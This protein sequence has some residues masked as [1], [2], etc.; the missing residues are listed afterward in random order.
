MAQ[1]TFSI[2]FSHGNQF[3]FG[4]L[5]FAAREDRNLELLTWG[6]APRHPALVY[7]TS[8]YYLIDP[9]TSG[10]ACSGLNPH[11]GPYYLSAKTSQGR[12]IRKTILQ[13]SVGASSSSSLGAT[14]YRDSIEDY[15]EIGSSACWNPAI[16][17][18]RISMVGPTKSNSQNNSSKYPTIGGSKASNE[19]TPSS[20]VV[21][22][23]NLD[24]NAVRL[25]TILESIQRMVPQDSPLMA[26][27]QQGVEAVKQHPQPAATDVWLITTCIGG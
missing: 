2:K 12:P 1:W 13:S 17:A 7:G 27:A 3:I 24:F 21:Q 10:R 8:P 16:K 4:S 20:K 26:L 6:P 5:M 22:N 11:A 14:P 19:Q 23:L 25:Q 18:H 15:S 9:S